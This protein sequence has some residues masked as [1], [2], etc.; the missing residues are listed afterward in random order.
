MDMCQ[1]EKA[2]ILRGK[3]EGMQT[4]WRTVFM[5]SKTP[6]TN[7]VIHFFLKMFYMKELILIPRY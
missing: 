2:A 6:A 5:P 4:F 3:V 1:K 7:S